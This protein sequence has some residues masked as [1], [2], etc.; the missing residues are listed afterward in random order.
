M[1]LLSSC[2]EELWLDSTLI[3]AY[4]QLNPKRRDEYAVYASHALVVG[5]YENT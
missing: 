1:D 3:E 5:R 4:H 2:S